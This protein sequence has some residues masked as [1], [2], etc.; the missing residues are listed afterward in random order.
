[1]PADQYRLHLNIILTSW[2]IFIY[3]ELRLTPPH[4]NPQ[5]NCLKVYVF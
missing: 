1:M 4:P 3:S 2:T 5:L